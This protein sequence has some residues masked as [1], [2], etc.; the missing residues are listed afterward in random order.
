MEQCS[1]EKGPWINNSHHFLHRTAS[2]SSWRILTIKM[3]IST[4][5]RTQNLNV[6]PTRRVVVGVDWDEHS[7]RLKFLIDSKSTDLSDCESVVGPHKGP[8]YPRTH[9]SVK[10]LRIVIDEKPTFHG[11]FSVITATRTEPLQRRIFFLLR[12]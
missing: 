12:L 5:F 2:S 7:S 10:T 1:L 6:S 9:L 11:P 3:G 4:V 8:R